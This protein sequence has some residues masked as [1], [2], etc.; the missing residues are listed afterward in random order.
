[1]SRK[2]LPWLLPLLFI[3]IVIF[4]RAC[5]VGAETFVCVSASDPDPD[6]TI[7]ACDSALARNGTQASLYLGRGIAHDAKAE[8]DLAISD[9]NRAI[10][11]DPKLDKAYYNRGNVYKDKSEYDRAIADFNQAIE[12]EPKNWEPF[13]NRG[14]AYARK[15]EFDRAISD[16]TRVIE[17]TPNSASGYINRA[18]VF[19]NKGEREKAI[20][21]YSR[22]HAILPNDNSINAALQRLG[23]KP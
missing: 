12:L 3:A 19:L 22:A 9:F 21:D 17:L 10:E 23:A 2:S 18:L 20:V 6:R 4:V 16:F 15:R 7:K 5:G 13:N 14:I 11:L 8:R 1:M